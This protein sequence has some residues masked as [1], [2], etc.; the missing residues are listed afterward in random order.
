MKT[1]CTACHDVLTSFELQMHRLTGT[2]RTRRDYRLCLGP[3]EEVESPAAEPAEPEPTEIK[4][5]EF[6]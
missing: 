6:T 5:R 1:R 2:H 3:V 4:F